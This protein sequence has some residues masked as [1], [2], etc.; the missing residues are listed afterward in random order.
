MLARHDESR[1]ADAALC[2]AREQ[3]LWTPRAARISCSPDGLSALL[4][5]LLR[6]RPQLVEHDSQL[7]DFLL[8]PLGRRVQTRHALSCVG[9]LYVA[10]AIPHEPT[11][12]Q[13]VVQNSGSTLAV[14][15]DRARTP[16]TAERAGNAFS[17]QILGDLLSET[18]AMNSRKIRSTTAA[19]VGSISR[20]PVVTFPPL[21]VLTT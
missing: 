11:D 12:V 2:Q 18:A 16:R 15:V 8:H 14:A 10:E 7:R 9:I 20:S 5:A 19:S 17:I 3:V 13:L 1:S 21:S 4:L 6:I